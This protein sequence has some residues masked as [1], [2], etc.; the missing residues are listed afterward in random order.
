MLERF[1]GRK[2]EKGLLT[3]IL[4]SQAPE[5]IAVYGRRRVGKTFLIHNTYR[6]EIVFEC[7][8]IHNSTLKRQLDSFGN[9]LTE[10]G[11]IFSGKPATNWLSAF[12]ML[13][14]FTAPRLGKKKIVLFFDEFPWLCSHR[15]GFLQAFEH[16]WNTWASLQNNLV[17]VI[18]GSAASWMIKNVVNNRGGLHNRITQKIR[19]LPFTLMETEE[20]LRARKVNLDRYQLLQLYMV[21]GGIPQYLKEIRTGESATQVIDRVCFTKDG[22]LYD[23]F[24]NLYYSLFELAS[25]HIEVVRALTRK[26]K[27]LTRSEIIEACKISSGGRATALLEELSES[28]FITAYIPFDKTIKDCIYRLTDEYS[29]FFIKFIEHRKSLGPGTWINFSREQAWKSWSGYAFESICMK[30]IPQLKKALEIGGVYTETS[31]WRYLP[32]ND[33]QGAQLDLLLDRKDGCINICE[34]KF[35][36]DS[37]VISKKYFAE[38][39]NKLNV[40]R[41]QTKTKKTLFLTMITTFGVKE[42]EYKSRV[43]QNEILMDALFEL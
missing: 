35:S 10:A 1:I 40:F 43:V 18:C 6:S 15:S 34:M 36:I 14:G 29:L 20:Y 7:S 17:V 24:K 2:A 8:G 11:Y 13:A 19:L 41:T 26:A 32:K 27:G 16:F 21:M 5:L 33:G 12:Q 9:A 4:K 37:Y 42:N 23:E 38:L 22:V 39:E 25:R 28:G 30:H 3:N 31:A